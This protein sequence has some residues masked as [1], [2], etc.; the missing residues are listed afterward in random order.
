[1]N[2]I[3]IKTY[4]QEEFLKNHRDVEVQD[5]SYIYIAHFKDFKIKE[6][7][8]P[9][10]YEKERVKNILLNKRKITLI[11]KMHLDVYDQ[12]VSKNDFEIF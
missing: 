6:S 4:N 11:N 5:S 3:P 12:A 8:S 9:L 7:V 10:S 1:M 2:Q